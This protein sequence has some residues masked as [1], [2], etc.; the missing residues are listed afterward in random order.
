M[1]KIIFLFLLSQFFAFPLISEP[2]YKDSIE[3]K[4]DT[5]L[6]KIV[7]MH[8][9]IKLF[10][11]VLEKLQPIAIAENKYFYI[12]DVD[13]NS[14]YKFIKISPVSFPIPKGIRAAMP[15][16]GYD[17]KC[18]C[19]VTGEAFDKIGDRVIIFHEFVHCAQFNSVELKLKENL[20]V[21]KQAMDKQDYMWELNYSFPYANDE[22]INT[23][24]EFLNVLD[25]QDST[26]IKY[27]RKNLKNMLYKKEFE[28]MTWQEWKE[29]YARF[30][31]NSLRK[32]YNLGIND[33]GKEKPFSRITFYSGGSRFIDYLIKKEPS[34]VNDLELLYKYITEYK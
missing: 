18:V 28:Y 30:V 15:I 5:S 26:A 6:Q 23:Y 31:E 3:M 8:K 12:F 14:N 33:F 32:Y 22:F 19:V 7:E 27:L 9:E 1:K 16:D 24:L 13:E 21:Y 11:K 25:K 4:Y 20:D 2:A 34:L 29:G 17:S 10:Y